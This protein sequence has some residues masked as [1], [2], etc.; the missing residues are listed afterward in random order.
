MLILKI[1][2]KRLIGKILNTVALIFKAQ[3]IPQYAFQIHIF[4]D[5]IPL[6]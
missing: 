1:A 5:N 6:S 4:R 3:G 2:L